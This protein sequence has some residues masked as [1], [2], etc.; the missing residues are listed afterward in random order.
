[1]EEDL[2][3]IDVVFKKVDFPLQEETCDDK[4]VE[5]TIINT[6]QQTEGLERRERKRARVVRVRAR[7]MRFERDS[8]QKKSVVFL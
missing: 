6:K 7:V 4:F 1:L 8:Q 2:E 5:E 3:P